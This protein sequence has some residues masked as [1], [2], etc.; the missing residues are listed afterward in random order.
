MNLGV[1]SVSSCQSPGDIRNRFS[2]LYGEN[3][4]LYRA[5]GRINL[6]GE[7]TDYNDGFVM[8]VAI[9]FYCWV[10]ICA[11]KGRRVDVYS[12]T[13]NEHRSFDLDQQRPTGDWSDY[14]Q[15]VAVM[16]Q[17]SGHHLQG[18]KILVSS[19]VPIGS[20][21]SS[22]AAL[23]VA[24]GL[25]FLGRSNAGDDH[26]QLAL[27]CQRAE[28]EFVGA[29]CG[30]MDQFIACHGKSGRLLMLDCRSL[31]HR[32]LSI[33]ENVRL[34]ICNT[35]V[36]HAI[37]AGEYNLRRSQCEQ[38][39]RLLSRAKPGITAL[40]DVTA[41]D[42]ERFGNSLPSEIL[43][44]CRHVVSENQRVLAAVAVL[45]QWDQCS[46]EQDRRNLEKFGSLM[47]ASHKS[48]R[49][50]YEVSCPEL[51]LMVNLANQTEGVYGARMTGGGF[52]GC[53]VNLVAVDAV[54]S[55]QKQIATQ[56]QEQT[57]ILPE[58]YVSTASEGA[59]RWDALA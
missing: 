11:A 29:R 8:P 24:T 16:L 41:N 55:F 28:N 1:T 5:P 52:G 4:V 42:L 14:V 25:A 33:P 39:V 22:S 46:R 13:L 38:G 53:T 36:R 23:E 15:G 45:E 18:A 32:L 47:A 3:C 56:Y 6:I 9:N 7:H 2:S 48:L 21:L 31:E 57:G 30:I 17:R 59:S 37:A 58:I 49:D 20:G 27:A 10:A 50:D 12:A 35:M 26:N 40:R 51:D 54:H 44:R 34:V 43:R 19:E